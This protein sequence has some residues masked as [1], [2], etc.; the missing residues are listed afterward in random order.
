MH[1]ERIF[2]DV[3]F[4]EEAV[5]EVTTFYKYCV[6]PELIGKWYSKKCVLPDIDV[7]I[8]C[9]K[10]VGSPQTDDVSS[11]A[12][13]QGQLHVPDS[14]AS[15]RQSPSRGQSPGSSSPRQSQDSPTTAIWCYCRQP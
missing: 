12:S 2:Q 13:S 15:Q 9:P 4:F 14:P 5:E 6:L 7:P 3:D 10:P 8:A 1:V 11:D